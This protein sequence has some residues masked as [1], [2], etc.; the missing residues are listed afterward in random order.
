M[1]RRKVLLVAAAV[2]AAMGTALVFLYVRGADTRAEQRFETV[3]VLRAVQVIE[4]GEAIESAAQAGKLKLQPVPQEQLL[5]GYQTSIDQLAGTVALTRIY[6]GEQVIADRFGG[7]TEMASSRLP[8]P[9]GMLAISINLSDTARVAGFVNPGSDV[10]IFHNGTDPGSQQP[11][12]RVLLK[13]VT[14]IGVGSTTPV[15]TTTTTADG[16]QTTEQLPRTLMTLALSKRQAEK[17]MLADST[18]ELTF[19]LLT[20][21]SKVGRDKGLSSVQLF[22]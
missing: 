20:D 10:T 4:P 21:S 1:D 19:A 6:P 15:S 5:S 16:Q 8:I 12:T 7:A 18:G 3:E 9:D 13:R 17:V 11:Y 2:V 14:V 22:D